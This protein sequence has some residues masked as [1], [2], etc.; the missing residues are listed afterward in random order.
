[1]IVVLLT[2][3]YYCIINYLIGYG[4]LQVIK[5]VINAEMKFN[6][7]RCIVTGII[8]LTV[9]AEIFSL[10]GKV[11]LVAHLFI[12]VLSI[13]IAVYYRKA[14]MLIIREFWKH[15]FSWETFLYV[16]VILLCAFFTSR[17]TLHTD[18]GI[19]HAQAIQW[20]EEY[21][22]VPGLGNLQLHFAY[23]SSY[24]AYAALMSLK[25]LTGVSLHTT[26][27]FIETVLCIYALLRLKNFWIHD[28]HL[29][30]A[31]C[32]AIL[33]YALVNL[34]GSMSPASDYA[35]NFLCIYVL[36]RWLETIEEDRNNISSYALLSVASVY[37]VTM[38][39]A[40]GFVVLL[41]VY[42]AVLLI[43]KKRWK[44]IITYV[45]LGLVILL[46]F[47]IRNIMISGWLIYPYAAIDLF[48][49][50]WK[51]PKQYLEIDAAQI[52]VWG[53]CLYD[54]RKADLPLM[55]WV[56]VW[57]GGQ[58]RYALMLLGTNVLA[59]LLTLVNF[60][61]ARVDRRKIEWPLLSF[62]MVLFMSLLLWFL[63]APFIRYG[64]AFILVL[65]FVTVG[66]WMKKWNGSFYKI[67][68]GFCVL[69][70]VLCFFSY[71]D[72]YVTDD[73]VFVKQK[74][75][76]P[77]YVLPKPY[78]IPEIATEEIDGLT[79]NYPATGEQIGY[80]PIPATSYIFMME[81]SELRGNTIESGFKPKPIE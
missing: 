15:L 81:R 69:G 17:G 25:F 29:A 5:K 66:Y 53:K 43:Q 42:P 19:Y 40:M 4:V 75:T 35:V 16:L 39:L 45:G 60:I 2:W 80:A 33:L 24:F 49:V 28:R 79:I 74:L 61:K 30:D 57:F 62:Y 10:F 31:T 9:Y 11:G 36:V 34:C 8:T 18:S 38:K 56:P 58:E 54:V 1:M 41:A 6:F 72:H 76:E 73:G 32:F 44:E 65:P 48:Q 51:I 47:L 12:L 14:F 77:Y 67:V 20:L 26:T 70:I 50:D 46:P 64:L 71:V 3:I 55:E 7:I 68:S 63:N 23:N 13:I 27:G 37:L 78:D 59:I 22:I 21:G 52:E